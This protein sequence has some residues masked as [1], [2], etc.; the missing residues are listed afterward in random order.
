MRTIRTKVYQ[1]GELNETAKKVAFDQLH[2][3]FFSDGYHWADAAYESLK[4]FCDTFEITYN[5]AEFTQYANVYYNI[6]RIEDDIL[7][8]SGKR[9]LSYILN[10]YG[11]L[12]TEAK[13]LGE[14]CKRGEKWGYKKRSRV[15]FTDT[16]CPFTGVCYDEDLL[17]PIRKFIKNCDKNTTFEDLLGDCIHSWEKSA[18]ADVQHQCSPEGLQELAEGNEIEFLESGKIFR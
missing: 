4:K 14:Y 16:S 8:L 7:Q 12:L 6:S 3:H 1:I 2:D 5:G 17:E 18:R 11:Y 10:N 15:F 9:L 13:G